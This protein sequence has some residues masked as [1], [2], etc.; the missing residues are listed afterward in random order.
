MM[1]VFGPT[2]KGIDDIPI[3]QLNAGKRQGC[4]LLWDLCFVN[5]NPVTPDFGYRALF[6]ATDFC[7]QSTVKTLQV[8]TGL[9]ASRPHE[10][11]VSHLHVPP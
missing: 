2:T 7:F 5:S 6:L 11:L 3:F 10:P 4:S 9:F 8:I 1:T